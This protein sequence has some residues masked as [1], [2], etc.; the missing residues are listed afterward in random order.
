MSCESLTSSSLF[1]QNCLDELGVST[2]Q[3]NQTNHHAPAPAASTRIEIP[4]AAR[5]AAGTTEPALQPVLG[6]QTELV[7]H[8]LSGQSIVITD[9]Q[10]H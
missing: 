3:P 2:H 10:G 5:P 1:A 4:L 7:R 8:A 9:R 6:V